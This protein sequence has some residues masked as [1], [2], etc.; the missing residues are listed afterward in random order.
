MNSHLAQNSLGKHYFKGRVFKLLVPVVST[1]IIA[2]IFLSTIRPSIK[3]VYMGTDKIAKNWF[4]RGEE[5][6]IYFKV[7]NPAI[8]ESD[9]EIYLKPMDDP[10]KVIK[11]SALKV[12]AMENRINVITLNTN[13]LEPMFYLLEC[14][15]NCRVFNGVSENPR[16]NFE[17]YP[18][19]FAVIEEYNFSKTTYKLGVN[20][21]FIAPR[22]MD[23]DMM[24][25]AGINLIRMDF[26]WS[27]VEKEK[28]VYI[29][30]EYRRLVDALRKRGITALFILDYGNQYYDDGVAP[31]S[32]VGREAF[33][34][35]ALESFK[36]FKG[37]DI[38]WE[39]WNEPNLSQFW[40]PKP[41]PEDYVRLLKAVYSAAREVGGVRLIAPGVSGFDFN[42]LEETFKLD[43]LN[44]IDAVSIHP[45]RST[46][47]ETVNLDYAKL[48][49]LLA[50]YGAPLKPIVSS[51]WGYCTGGSYGNRVSTAT[52][53]EYVVRMF[54]INIMNG[55][56]VS[57][58][59]DWKDD[60]SNIHDSEQNFGL[61]ADYE[62]LKSIYGRPAYFIKP[63]YYAIYTLTSQLNG[64]QF[65]G[66]VETGS[67]E[68]YIL[69]FE[70]GD[71]VK[72]YVCWTTERAHKVRLSIHA[73]TLEMVKLFGLKSIHKSES[74][75]YELTLTSAPIFVLPMP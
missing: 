64:F 46:N 48:R 72:K 17:C 52:Q 26:L 54:L 23:L 2:V 24:K 22:E 32:D 21:H 4:L 5:A 56:N 15:F 12:K 28:G 75:E 16:Y 13:S 44:C 61:I 7:F 34:K 63:A 3:L 27:E 31:Y 9:L 14:N 39:V 42:F 58:F 10:S 51:E 74:G 37:E 20:I 29:F 33:A 8:V 18:W 60:G 38:I 45:Y 73:K 1:L 50:L 49:E 67:R 35:F 47:P 40:K 66:R 68:D 36:E 11:V 57:V 71:G 53:A 6:R 43:M 19:L 62:G 41:N 25:Y 70:N 65:R 69:V 30:R 59:Y 55:V